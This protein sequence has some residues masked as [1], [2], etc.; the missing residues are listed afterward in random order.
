MA[1]SKLYEGSVKGTDMTQSDAYR[2]TLKN[3]LAEN[4]LSANARRTIL[5]SLLREDWAGQE[6]WFVSLFGD[7]DLSRQSQSRQS[8]MIVTWGGVTTNIGGL[9]ISGNSRMRDFWRRFNMS[10]PIPL[11]IALSLKPRKWIPV[12]AGLTGHEEAAVRNAAISSL[13]TFLNN[14]KA[15]KKARE[16][17]ARALLPWLTNPDWA[18]VQGRAEFIFS[19]TEIDLPESI[20]GLLW[21]LDNDDDDYTRDAVVEALA[22]H[23]DSRLA[24]ALKGLLPSESNEDVRW[25]IVTALA[26]C[27][28]FS[29]EEMASAI[30]AYANLAAT[31]EGQAMIKEISAGESGKILPLN[32]FIGQTLIETDM[33]WA[34][35]GFATI[36]F[37]R[38][39]E[40]PPAAA[41]IILNKIRALPLNIARARLVERIGE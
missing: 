22:Q 3:L 10:D 26:K 31:V 18:S 40:A 35:E 21:V 12:I 29:E 30:E 16:E 2:T 7:P 34:T 20:P 36:L 6:E 19:L 28:G 5:E 17:A 25:Q 24:Q 1:L 32:V 9:R 37:D 39:K 41:L 4:G 33:S 15:E 27:G 11:S 23:C 38:L 13:V 8:Q 14:D